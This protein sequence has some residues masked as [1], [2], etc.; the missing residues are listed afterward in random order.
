M[1]K[2]VLILLCAGSMLC[3]YSQ[4]SAVVSGRV[5]DSLDKSPLAYVTISVT[6]NGKLV[7]GNITDAQGRYVIKG[8]TSGKY[9]IN[10]SYV[11]YNVASKQLLVG[12]KNNILDLGITELS[13]SQNKID[14]V[15]V[16]GQKQNI[17]ATLDKKTYSMSDNITQA[18]GSVLDAMRNMP[19]ITVDQEGKVV[20]R[21]SDK[22]AVLID[23]Q[24][25]AIT[26]YGSQKGLDNIPVSSID[27]IEII[28]NPSAKYDASGMAG[29]VNIIYKKETK[30]GLHGDIGFT[31]GIGNL[32]SRKHDLPTGLSSYKNNSKYIPSISL[33]YKHDKLSFFIQGN[34]T[35][36]HRLPNNE[37]TTRT[38]D[39]AN[40]G[41]TIAS[42][43]AE[44]RKQNHY[45]IKGGFD[46]EINDRNTMSVFAV[47]DY[48]KHIDTSR[49]GYFDVKTMKS[50]R[51]WGFNETESTGLASVTAN[52]KY[53]FSQPGHQITNSVQFTK[54]WEDEAYDLYEYTDGGRTGQDRTHIIAPEYVY[55]I[56]SDY[57]K[58]L[59]WGRFEAGLGGR[60]RNM[61]IDYTVTQA[62]DSPM[63]PGLGD[64][65]KWRENM[66]SGY[67][68]FV[69]ERP[70]FDVEA[71]LRA[72]QTFVLY[73]IDPNGKY[74]PNK[75]DKYDYLSLLP[76]IRFTYNL[77]SDHKLSLF[78]NRRI[79]RPGEGELRIF[80]KYDDPEMFKLGNP[81]LRPQYTQNIELAYKFIWSSGS[82]YAAG[83]HKIIDDY[84]TR[85][86]SIDNN[87]NPMPNQPAQVINKIYENTGRARNTGIEVVFDQR[88]TKWWNL[89]A[90]ANWFRNKIDAFIGTMYFPY[91]RPFSIDKSADN[92]WYAKMN[93]QFTV[94]KGTQIHIS[95]LYFAPKNSVQGRD[96]ERWSV[97]AGIKKTLYNG[98]LEIMLSANDIFNK[99]A[100]RQ[101]IVGDGFTAL[102]ENFNE[103][104]IFSVGLKYKF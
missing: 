61:P 56:N 76:N 14:D 2:F 52:H 92:T 74:Y 73:E 67:A 13:P 41:Q 27:R 45:Y 98:R 22:I 37:F 62:P 58:P 17:S 78:Y 68:N 23:G 43:V 100:I 54:G 85:I 19:G 99:M 11:G 38:Y 64:W 21:G 49:I 53:R 89:S 31:Y 4:N 82:F 24:Q 65:S 28:N 1:R 44:N 81:Y 71:G 15:V 12:Q 34:F 103:N 70:K 42:Q 102:Y 5:I 104:Q 55:L 35:N 33:N 86:Y 51:N 20:L 7:Y 60:L 91:E 59:H 97:D 101:Q 80:P 72:E 40:G 84:Y 16:V 48:E 87:P 83:Y 96:L 75:K 79:D 94:W 30:T 90:S 66:I 39:A 63:Y 46:W 77:N 9:T 88:I 25:S 36:Q 69:Y 57:V 47:Y 32:T 6:S 29:I 3:A 10:A 50:H 26:G 8:L 95:G 93:N 18:G